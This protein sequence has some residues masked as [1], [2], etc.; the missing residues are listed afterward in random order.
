MAARGLFVS[1]TRRDGSEI[2]NRLGEAWIKLRRT[3][4][5]ALGQIPASGHSE[6]DAQP[7][8]CFG[9]RRSDS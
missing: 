3:G 4:V 8:M 5:C 2:C 6:R 9:V 1:P 7:V